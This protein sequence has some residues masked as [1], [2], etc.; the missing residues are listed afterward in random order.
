MT[1]PQP[2]NP[3]EHSSLKTWADRPL[4]DCSLFTSAVH[5]LL[6]VLLITVSEFRHSKLSL[7]SS[8]LTYTILLSLVPMLAMSTAVVKELGGGDQ[9]RKAAYTYIESLEQTNSS[10]T[11]NPAGDLAPQNTQPPATSRNLTGHLRSAIDKL[12]DYVDRTN[13]ATLGTIGVLGILISVLLMLGHIESAMN[14]IWKVS[15]ARSIPRKI[16]DYLTLMVLLPLSINIA[17]AAS[18]FLKSP[19]LALKMD[20]LIPL[21][22]LQS[23]LLKP[24]PIFFIALTFYVMYIFFPNTRVKYFP[25]AVGAT[26]AALLWFMVQ[27]VYITLQLGVSNYNAIYGSFATLPLFLVWMYLGWIFILTGAQ[28][29]FAFQNEKT[30]RLLPFRGSPSLKLGAAFDIMDYIYTAFAAGGPVTA[31]DLTDKLSHYS[32]LIIEDALGE[33]I[34]SGMVHTSQKDDRLLPIVPADQFDRQKIVN[35]ILGTDSPDTTGGNLSRK[36]IEAAGKQSGQH[37]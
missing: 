28:V 33:L 18:A 35:I 26:L 22:W 21:E 10:E 12:F 30:Y 8:A 13:F 16:A 15:S 29:A 20:K 17:F 23:L 19:V 25:A 3:S 14:A 31:R 34:H 37:N 6:R 4:S 7:R 27:N 36:A 11:A 5:Y 24:L 9:L 32:P 2:S 1:S